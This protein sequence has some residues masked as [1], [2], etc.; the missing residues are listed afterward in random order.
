MRDNSY[1]RPSAGSRDTHRSLR[2]TAPAR[3]PSHPAC[4]IFTVVLML[5]SDAGVGPAPLGAALHLALVQQLGRRL[6]PL[7]L[8]EP[9]DERFARIFLRILLRRIRAR[10]VKAR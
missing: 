10:Q 9:A 5:I 4:V 1:R 2:Q 3:N 6:E 7:V 8:E